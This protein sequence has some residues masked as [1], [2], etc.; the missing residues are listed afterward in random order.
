MEWIDYD[1]DVMHLCALIR[2]DE[3]FEEYIKFVIFVEL[4]EDADGFTFGAADGDPPMVHQQDGLTVVFPSPLHT[5]GQETE[6]HCH[7]FACFAIT[8]AVS[9]PAARM[10]RSWRHWTPRRSWQKLT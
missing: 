5:E 7:V 2:Q 3:H 10:V 9:H 4:G 6:G 1:D 8:I